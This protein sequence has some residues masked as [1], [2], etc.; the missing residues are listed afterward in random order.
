MASTITKN[1]SPRVRYDSNYP[2]TH[3]NNEAYVKQLAV[4][5]MERIKASA[6]SYA[7]K[8]KGVKDTGRPD[9]EVTVTLQDLKE[10]II[11]SN[12][13]SPNGIDIQFSAVG[14]LRNPGPAEKNGLVT[15]EQRSRFPSVDRIDSSKGYIKGNIQLTAKSYNLGK[16]SYNIGVTNQPAEKATIRF[17][18]AELEI[19]NPTASFLANTLKE[20][21]N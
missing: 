20:L 9:K 18:G 8:N 16:S 13:K 21:T 15:S 2:I 1:Y 5:A 12:G 3:P 11:N 6:K 10:V 4:W 19:T 14:I 17:K 7:K